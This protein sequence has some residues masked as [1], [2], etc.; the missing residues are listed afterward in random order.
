[1]NEQY[2]KIREY[3]KQIDA[4]QKQMELM[5]QMLV[6][7]QSSNK[8][9]N[10]DDVI[11]KSGIDLKVGRPLNTARRN[12]A[13]NESLDFTS[14]LN[15][16]MEE[17][18]KRLFD[19]EEAILQKINTKAMQMAVDIKQSL[20]DKV[21]ED[22]IEYYEQIIRSGGGLAVTK[23]AYVSHYMSNIDLEDYLG[24]V[25]L[26][27]YTKYQGYAFNPQQAK[28]FKRCIAILEKDEIKM[29]YDRYEVK[30]LM[31]KEYKLRGIKFYKEL[32]KV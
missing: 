9:E 29:E 5:Q 23:Y 8:A 21:S 19:T 14:S 4:M 15:K 32:G 13:V 26:D 24:N 30:W 12:A 25:S 3:E 20:I 6:Q 22:K 7:M 11:K 1:M 18:Q 31:S 2:L 16:M 10:N 28:V 27:Q 17:K